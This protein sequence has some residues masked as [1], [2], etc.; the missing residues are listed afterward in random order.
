M[1]KQFKVE[2]DN[3]D[4]LFAP[5]NDFFF[6]LWIIQKFL[7]MQQGGWV[8]LPEDALNKKVLVQSSS[9]LKVS[10]IMKP[11]KS[12]HITNLVATMSVCVFVTEFVVTLLQ[13]ETM[14]M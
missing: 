7:A 3:Y 8:E 9:C 4:K 14:Y 12:F 5:S 13:F 11:F 2:S 1:S 6:F 10:N